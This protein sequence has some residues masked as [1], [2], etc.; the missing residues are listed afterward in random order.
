[1]KKEI[2]LIII[3]GIII[4]ALLGVFLFIKKLPLKETPPVAGGSAGIIVIS[5]NNSSVSSPVSSPLKIVG[6]VT[7]KDNWVGFEGQAG[8]VKLLDNLGKELAFGILTATTEWTTLPTNFETTLNFQSASVQSGTLVFHNEN[9]SGLP[10]K[11]KEFILPVKIVKSLGETT[12]VLAYFS[13]N[14][15]DPEYSCNK[16]FAV[17]R[18]VPKTTAVARAALD[19]LLKGLTSKE[20]TA[21]FFTSINQGVK[22]QSLKIENN[23]AHVDFD[24][25]LEY[26]VGGSCRVSAISAQI[27]QTLKQFSTVKNVIISINGRTE[28]ILQP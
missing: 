27:M 1:M 12:K 24:E 5:L 20:Q 6:Y 13:N 4:V 25:Q 3:F 16:V 18:D 28:D 9:P 7:G 21:G 26:Q 11:N 23:T 22:I 15:M 8:T 14:K 19:E 17:E 2:W 10:E